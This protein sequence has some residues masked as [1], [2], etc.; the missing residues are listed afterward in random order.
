MTALLTA[1]AYVAIAAPQPDYQKMADDAKWEWK[2]DRATAEHSAK[3]LPDGYKV[4]IKKKD[5]GQATISFTKD[6]KEV[7][8]LDGHLGTVFILKDGIL[9]YA[10]YGPSQTGCTLIA[11]DLAAGKQP[12]KTPLKGLG[13]IAH[14]Q[15]RNAVSLELI[16]GALRVLGHE[17]A[18]DYIEF[19]DTKEG[20]TVGHKVFK[21]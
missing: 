8:S 2:D 18:G 1:L 15:Y 4:E 14:F 17:S 10:D 6:G 19:V 11:R 7:F 12:W 20:K 5:F 3:N 9:Y 13:P 21:R 16:D